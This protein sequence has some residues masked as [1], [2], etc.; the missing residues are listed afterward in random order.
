MYNNI[1][2]N[3]TWQSQE[4]YKKEWLHRN[5]HMRDLLD[6]YKKYT[7]TE[8]GCGPMTPFKSCIGLDISLVDMWKWDKLNNIVFDLNTNRDDESWN[9][10]P[11]TDVGVLSGVLEYV[12]N[13]HLVLRKLRNIHKFVLYSY[14]KTE[15]CNVDLG[16]IKNH[17]NWKNHKLILLEYNK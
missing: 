9:N 2:N 8:Y 14:E 3:K 11:K 7:Y 10:L 4:R 16:Q 6:D 15:F 12:D 13:P 5:E 1:F 17:S